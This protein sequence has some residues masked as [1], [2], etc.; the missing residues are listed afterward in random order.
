MLA[1]LPLDELR[2]YRPEV[3]EP[4]DFGRFWAGELSAARAHR[5]EPSFA[6]ARSPLRHAAVY[7]VTFAGHG[8]DPVKAWLLDPYQSTGPAAVI[9]QFAGYGGGRGDP[10]DWLTWSCAGHPHLIMDCR[11]QGGGY[12]GA[13]TPDPGGDGAPSTPG[14][15]TRGIAAP[16]SHYYTRLFIDAALAVDAVRAH[17]AASGRAVVTAGASQG[18]GLA[19]AAA[20]LGRDV[21]AVLPDVPFLAHPRRAAQIT[22]SR[23]Y[24]ELAE[25]CRVYPDRTGQVF[26]TLAYL[27]VVNHAKRATAPALFSAGLADTTTPPSTVFAAFN[28]YAG[29]KDIAVYEFAGHEGGGTRHFLAQLAFLRSAGLR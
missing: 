25:Y 14:F 12:L 7:D 11:G 29:R 20:H 28:H 9:V 4:A 16:G 18:G 15:L 3:A 13:D 8:G 10:L 1:D 19:I 21:A 24:A 23:P 17:P 22:D 26:G 5:G 2:E 27:D 6:S